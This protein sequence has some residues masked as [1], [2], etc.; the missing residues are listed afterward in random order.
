MITLNGNNV[1]DLNQFI[2]TMRQAIARGARLPT[3]TAYWVGGGRARVEC[4]GNV[5]Y[6]GG[7]GELNAM[8][9]LLAALAACDVDVIATHASLMGL[10]IETLSVE[11]GG[12]Y[13]VCTYPQGHKDHLARFT[14]AIQTLRPA[15]NRPHRVSSNCLLQDLEASPPAMEASAQCRRHNQLIGGP[16]ASGLLD[17]LCHLLIRDLVGGLAD[18]PRQVVVGCFQRRASGCSRCHRLAKV[19]IGLP[20]PLTTAL[21]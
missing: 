2:E 3:L 8:R 15:T 19:R 7:D 5:L 17:N 16:F 13:N 20:R 6:I 11:V 12:H 14:A 4:D 21:A 18:L 9:V 1:A 10:E